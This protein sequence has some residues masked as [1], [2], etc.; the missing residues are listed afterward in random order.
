MECG[1][2]YDQ[3]TEYLRPVEHEAQLFPKHDNKHAL[4]MLD[5]NPLH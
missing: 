1:I 5:F 2:K 4:E 3:N